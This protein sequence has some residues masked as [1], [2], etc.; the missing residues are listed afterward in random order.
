MKLFFKS[1]GLL[2]VLPFIYIWMIW[3]SGTSCF[4]GNTGHG[5]GIAAGFVM[6]G[7]FVAIAVAFFEILGVIAILHFIL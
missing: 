2:S 4:K 3:V 6:I 1:I 5:S 7:A